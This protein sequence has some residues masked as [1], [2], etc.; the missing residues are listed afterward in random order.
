M[1]RLLLIIISL[2]ICIQA[3]AQQLPTLSF[4]EDNITALNPSLPRSEFIFDD[5]SFFLNTTY[6]MQWLEVEDEPRTFLFQAGTWLPDWEN[7]LYKRLGH[8][9]AGIDIVSDD[10]G[11]YSFTGVY[12]R[13]GHLVYLGNGGRYRSAKTF[14]AGGLN[15]GAIWH[16]FN[17]EDL[18]SLTDPDDMDII[19]CSG[20]QMVPDVGM[21]ISFNHYVTRSGRDFSDSQGFY[22]GFSMPQS[23]AV[24]PKCTAGEQH[25]FERVRHYY[26]TAGARLG[27]DAENFKAEPSIVFHYAPGVVNIPNQNQTIQNTRF[28]SPVH[29]SGNMEITLQEYLFLGLGLNSN[30]GFA[31]RLGVNI[32]MEGPRNSNGDA[33]RIGIGYLL[34]AYNK[35]N[36][37][38]N[39]LEF[40]ATYMIDYQEY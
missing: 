18:N 26:L 37:M 10:T 40:T 17:V 3:V 23:M 21:G 16:R 33:L 15:I 25:E 27:R 29:I 22:V 19:A 31:T 36:G 32:P 5:Y 14:I 28:K 35:V 39:T 12:G 38:G 7:K 13:L 6:R 24:S 8:T 11:A 4:F 30:V 20:T 1:N 2:S 9:H 34:G